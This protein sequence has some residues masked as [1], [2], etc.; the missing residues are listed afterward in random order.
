M[1]KIAKTPICFPGFFHKFSSIQKKLATKFKQQYSPSEFQS[2]QYFM[3]ESN[4][5]PIDHRFVHNWSRLVSFPLDEKAIILK[6]YK[7]KKQFKSL[8]E[9][10]K[11]KNTP[12]DSWYEATLFFSSNAELQN[13][14]RSLD[15][16]N[17]RID[18]MFDLLDCLAGLSAFSHCYLLEAEKFLPKAIVVTAAVDH[19]NFF[20]PWSI[21]QD[22]RITSYPSWAG[23]SVIEIRNDLFQKNPDTLSEELIGN[24]IF[25]MAAR[26]TDQRKIKYVVPKLDF[27]GEEQLEKC[28][29]RFE[30]GARNQE[31]RKITAKYAL[32]MPPPN[33][34]E[35]A[36][37]HEIFKSCEKKK[38][39]QDF[40]YQEDTLIHK[41]LMMHRQ[42][43]NFM[44]TVKN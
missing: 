38:P 42:N 31:I 34:E 10:E 4:K 1:I 19:I 16:K 26:K 29:I 35:I 39:G 8:L 15:T 13:S 41:T 6:G 33:K 12:R 25:L 14:L 27:D 5:I 37:M 36:D 11:L 18:L 24:A 9:E 17:M 40:F 7:G 3:P 21:F 20:K 2:T 44:G 23:E 28:Q 22:L 30:L 32:D 43:Q